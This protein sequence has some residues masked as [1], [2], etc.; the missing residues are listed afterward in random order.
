MKEEGWVSFHDYDSDYL[1]SSRENVF[2]FKNGLLYKH[3]T[4]LNRGVYYS[5]KFSSL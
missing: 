5:D 3:N 1:F 4:N 2:S